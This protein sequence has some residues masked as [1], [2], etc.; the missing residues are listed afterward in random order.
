MNGFRETASHTNG[1]TDERESLGLQRL[2][3]E[4]KKLA[5]SNNR[6]K[7]KFKK[8]SKMAKIR[9]FLAKRGKS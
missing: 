4:T 9:K 8:N 7:K 6:L 2:R 5:N 3:R 1:R